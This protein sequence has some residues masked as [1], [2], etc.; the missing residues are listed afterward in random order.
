MY[1][2]THDTR[3][4]RV[5]LVLVPQKLRKPTTTNYQTRKL[6]RPTQVGVWGFRLGRD[7]SFPIDV[8]SAYIRGSS[9][10]KEN[11]ISHLLSSFIVFSLNPESPTIINLHPYLIV[12]R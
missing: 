12:R 4:S 10:E 5:V 3:V 1:V 8:S 7:G 2:L 6:K 11:K 9:P